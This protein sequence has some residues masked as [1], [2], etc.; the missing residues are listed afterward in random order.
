MKL[1]RETKNGIENH[2]IWHVCEYCKHE[3]NA[4]AAF[5]HCPNCG[6]RC[7]IVPMHSDRSR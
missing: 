2:E 6:G 4:K 3:F 1:I 5:G 7:L